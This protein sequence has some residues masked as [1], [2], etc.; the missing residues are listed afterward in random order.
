MLFRSLGRVLASFVFLTVL[1]AGPLFGKL[2]NHYTF[3]SEATVT[4][5]SSGNGRDAFLDDLEVAWIED[6][7]RGGVLELGG[8][9]NGFLVAEIPVLPGDGFT[10]MMWAY[11]D[12]F[13]AGGGGGANDGLFQVQWSDA[14]PEDILTPSTQGGEK[15]IG[16][17]V[18]KADNVVWGRMHQE[19]FVQVNLPKEF[20]MEDNLWT[21]LTY[22]GNGSLFEVLVD[23]QPGSGP[24]I[25]YDGTLAEHNTIYIGR[26]GAETWG[27]RLDDFRVYSHA[28]TN[29]EILE[30]VE[31]EA[32][33]VIGDFNKNQ[34]LDAE[35][36]DLLSAEIR[37]MT[38]N[39]AFDLDNNQLVNDADHRVWVNEL[40]NTYYG[41]AD[42]N[43]E[44]NSTDFVTV[45]L[46]GEY[47]DPIAGNSNWGEG[48]FNGDG[49]FNST[50]FVTA[51]LDG[52]YEL[53]PKPAVSAVPEPSAWVLLLMG[54]LAVV[55]KRR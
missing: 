53:G 17:W 5:D 20:A 30:I 48:D 41:D 34:V 2:E 50:D 19:D 29:E 23:G 22:R 3:D 52:G 36:I 43:G 55:R 16:G 4:S 8:S 44:F 12:E 15:L 40:K 7:D 13:L 45:F 18:Q 38:N 26:Q 11:R 10:I 37:A 33:G 28:L 9:T 27:G 46:A 25:A 1:A 24:A 42:L 39:V 21:H 49:D 35:D 51:F 47:E 14:L 54:L 31:G 6:E 32:P